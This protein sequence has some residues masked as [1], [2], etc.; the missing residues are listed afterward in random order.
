MGD[1]IMMLG[2]SSFFASVIAG[3]I[4]DGQ[5]GQWALYWFPLFNAVAFV[6]LFFFFEE[7][8]Y[9]RSLGRRSDNHE[10][11]PKCHVLRIQLRNHTMVDNKR[12]SKYSCCR[13]N[14][15]LWIHCHGLLLCEIWQVFET[16]KFEV[17]LD[18]CREGI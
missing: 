12:D 8:M 11:N 17:V 10:S 13:W 6:I 18:I 9:Y 14:A 16:E 1:Y 4:G 7:T 3:S 2:G 5:D 15:C